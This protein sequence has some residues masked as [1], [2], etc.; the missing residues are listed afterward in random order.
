MI[1]FKGKFCEYFFTKLKFYEIFF[2]IN[3]NFDKSK[4]S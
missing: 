1:F 4:K 3:E 2:N